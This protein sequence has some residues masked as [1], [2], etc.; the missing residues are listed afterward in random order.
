MAKHSSW[1]HF[2]LIAF[3]NFRAMAL[4][5]GSAP[6]KLKFVIIFK[7]LKL[8]DVKIKHFRA[9]VVAKWSNLLCFKFS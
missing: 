6:A 9:A 7:Y 1:V 4:A 8:F 2:T 5:T 3:V